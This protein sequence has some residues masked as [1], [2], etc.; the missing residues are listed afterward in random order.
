MF[1]IADVTVEI[2]RLPERLAHLTEYFVRF[3]RGVR[4]PILQ[5]LAQRLPHLGEDVKVIRH[6]NPRQQPI[7]LAIVKPQILLNR[8]RHARLAQ[9]TRP[10]PA[11]EH[12]FHPAEFLAF[13]L[14]L[15]GLGPFVL[16]FGGN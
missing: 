9:G 4:F 5:H 10:E 2:I 6:D 12:E 7:R 11:I 14:Q 13:V 16:E 8:L 15:H 1:L 3:A